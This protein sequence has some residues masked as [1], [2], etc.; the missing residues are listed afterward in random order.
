MGACSRTCKAMKL[1]SVLALGLL[2]ALLAAPTDANLTMETIN[3]E[4]AAGSKS[5][6]EMYPESLVQGLDQENQPS[7]VVP[8]TTFTGSTEVGGSCTGKVELYQ[9]GD[10]TGWKASFSKNIPYGSIEPWYKYNDKFV[11]AGAKNNDASSI[12]VPAG[13]VA[14][15]YQHGDFNIRAK[16]DKKGAWE[17]R[18]FAG[19]YP[20]KKFLEGGAKND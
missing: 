6:G 15:L 20:Y 7:K 9:H 3:P 19:S 10:F 5:G 18:F 13:C 16:R 17:A 2:L 12:K 4:D 1:C 8:E 11:A 14:E